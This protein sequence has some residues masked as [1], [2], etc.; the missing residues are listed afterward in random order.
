MNTEEIKK[1]IEENYNTYKSYS[2]ITSDYRN[3]KALT[4]AYN[5]RQL[6]EMLQ[7]ADDAKTDKIFLQLDTQNNILT[8]ANNGISF[9]INGLGSLMLANNSPKNKRDF[10]G[11]KGLG[12]RSIL[13]WVNIVKIKTKTCV[14]EFSKGIARNHF[15][16]L[17]PDIITRQQIIDKEKDLPKGDLPIAIL[18]IPDFKENNIMQD[19]ETI[20]ELTYKKE[21][22]PIIIEQ[23]QTINEEVLL[24]LNHTSQ[25]TISTTDDPINK[26]LV[27]TKSNI[28]GKET[29]TINKK[30]WNIFDSG[31]R[32]L[33]NTTEKFY[34][35]KI[36][37]QDDLSDKNTYFATYFPTQVPTHL[38]YLIHATFDLDPSRNHLN[39]SSN[40]EYILTQIAKTLKETAGTEILNKNA[41][42]WKALD[43]LSTEGKSESPNLIGFF[44]NI[45]NAKFELAIYPTVNNLYKDI[46]E[47]KFYGN[48]FSEWV[49]RNKLEDNFSDLLLPVSP[50]KTEITHKIT[51]KYTI[52][53]WKSIFERIT[54]HIV[55]IDERVALIKLLVK[56]NFKELHG[57]FLPLLIDQDK[58]TVNSDT[59]VFTLRKG[60]TDIY[61]IPDYVKI[62]FIDDAF[63]FKLENA[64][65]QE[66]EQKRNSPTEHKSRALKKTVDSIVN[67][68]SNDITD[69]VRNITK[70]FNSKVEED[71]SKASE[72]IIPFINSL[73]QIFKQKKEGEKTAVDNIKILNRKGNLILTTEVFLGK[74]YHYGKATE[75]LFQ[76]IF[77]DEN[78]LIGNEFWRLDVGNQNMD[79]LD[80]FFVWLGVNKY[81]KIKN[82]KRTL[83]K[84]SIDQYAT[85]VF[86]EIG[87]PSLYSGVNYDAIQV[88]LFDELIAKKIEIEKLIA[89]IAL[90]KKLLIKLDSETNGETFAH[91]YSNNTKYEN[92]KPSYFMYQINK[93]EI[94]ENTFVDFEFASYL[95]L[96]SV[97]PENPLFL[98]LNIDKTLV[99]DILKKLGAKMSFNDLNA[100]SVYALMNHLKE[101]DINSKNARK[102]Y[103][104]AF[105][106]FKNHKKLNFEF[107][108]KQ[109]HLIAVKNAEKKYIPTK[110]VYYSDNTT[111]PSKIIEDFWIFDFPKRSGEKQVSD[112]FGI[113]T[114]KNIL[115]EIDESKIN[116]HL[117][118]EE[119]DRWFHKIKTYLLTYRLS[120]FNTEESIKTA[121]NLIRSSSIKIV[122][123]LHYSINGGNLKKLLPN[124]F[125]NNEKHIFYISAEANYSF[126]QLKNTPAFC[127]A[128]AE[129]LCVVFE[130]NEN[131]DDFRNIFKDKEDLKDSTYLIETK[132]L[133]DKF[134]EA[135]ALLGIDKNEV[136]FWKAVTKEKIAVFP[137]NIA[138]ISELKTNILNSIDYQLPDYYEL[139]DFE[140]FSNQQSFDFIEDLCSSQNINLLEIKDKLD[141]FPGLKHFHLSKFIQTAIDLEIWWN[142][143][144]WLDLSIKSKEEQIGFE[145]KRNLY[146]DSAY[147]IIRILAD[148]FTW[149]VEIN[150]EKELLYELTSKFEILI[151]I[152]KLAALQLEHKYNELITEF[153]IS[154][155]ELNLELKSL[156]FFEGHEEYLRFAFNEITKVDVEENDNTEHAE[157]IEVNAII[158]S[159]DICSAPAINPKDIFGNKKGKTHSKKRELQNHKAGKRAEKLV[160]DKLMELYPDGEIRWISGNSEDNGSKLDDTKGYDITYKKIKTDKQW[161]YLEV[162]S[163]SS[164]NRFIISAN[165]VAVGIENKENYHLALVSGL[166][167]SIVEDFFLNET[168]LAEFN[169][170]RNSL[171]IRPLDYEVFYSIPSNKTEIQQ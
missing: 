78:Y 105:N 114:F 12:F 138:N 132:L 85:F 99:L 121:S 150:Y 19:W 112:Y 168:R 133:T 167:I 91:S 164:G 140:L 98:S 102:I 64:F 151:Q 80:D 49:M 70:A 18:A 4:E 113:K 46:K 146:F 16:Q 15:E 125:I 14:L 45:E 79:Y 33:P 38:P 96:N 169:L 126:E 8:I 128:F 130:V 89:W 139:V 149:K 110:E 120:S 141:S 148:Q 95:G 17:I 116:Y 9:D 41:A 31:E 107:L 170:L 34:K 165:E 11:N 162:K 118:S 124:E 56:E 155:E 2:R 144:W 87:Y 101:K 54:D 82:L 142:K 3:E 84:T 25:I 122:A 29:L 75:T 28:Y 171:S 145:N 160:R 7:N 24:F 131:K 69:V 59:E 137:E 67:L 36:A 37:W 51:S 47:I 152:E 52:E 88:D 127:E 50:N 68:G 157:P 39:K 71:T 44:K 53:E 26:H 62:S 32:N 22:E 129:I 61:Q 104:L 74:E 94:I 166:N 5:G 55:N 103:L 163:S 135:C 21:E 123:N 109:T 73:F 60:S 43:F 81:T 158:T 111:L 117:K 161:K 134:E 20:I 86:K 92:V 35:Y 1:L 156:L 90:D 65:S 100:E 147:E 6:L 58:N 154:T 63:Y 10:I 97:N 27:R 136:L 76:G 153:N 119:F 40:N 83:N 72:L 106:F 48:D 30:T 115:I 42:D 143:A 159:I 23:F 13:N 66:I 57:L 93:S 77:D 108:P